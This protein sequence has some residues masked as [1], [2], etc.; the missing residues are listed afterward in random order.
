MVRIAER[1]LEYPFLLEM[2]SAKSAKI[3]IDGR[4]VTITT[5]NILLAP[6]VAKQLRGMKPIPG[7]DGMK[8]GYI[9]ASGACLTFSVL[10][11][12]RRIIGCVTKFPGHARRYN[13]CRRL[14][15][16]AYDPASLDR[17]VRTAPAPGRTRRGSGGGRGRSTTSGRGRT[18]GSR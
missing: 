2:T 10:R 14:I 6:S 11:N 4:E 3:R 7:V 13:F 5:T 17:P 15:D 18:S 16:W 12:G 1:L 8:T 9:D